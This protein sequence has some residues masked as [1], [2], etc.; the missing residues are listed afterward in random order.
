MNS[1]VILS[2][3]EKKYV[4]VFLFIDENIIVIFMREKKKIKHLGT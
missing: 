3:G 1:K 4:E 2:L